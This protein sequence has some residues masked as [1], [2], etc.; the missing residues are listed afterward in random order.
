MA[1]ILFILHEN[2]W[3]CYFKKWYSYLPQCAEKGLAKIIFFLPL[4]LTNTVL[5]GYITYSFFEN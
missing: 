3:K 5:L 2:G 1:D 4:F